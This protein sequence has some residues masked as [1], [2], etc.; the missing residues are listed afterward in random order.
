[1]QH[2]KI[3]ILISLLLCSFAC[4]EDIPDFELGR[5]PL[6]QVFFRPQSIRN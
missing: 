6:L 3:T 4:T 1:M 5:Y 2:N